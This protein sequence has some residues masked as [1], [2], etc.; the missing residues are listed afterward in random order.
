MISPRL[1]PPLLFAL[2]V[3]AQARA[4]EFERIVI[5]DNFPGAYQVE[6]ADVNGD[7]KPDVIAV[8]GG[9]CA[10]YENPSWK[11]RVVTTSKQTPGIISSA[12][13]DL[14][15]DGKAEIAIA[16]EFAM[17][18]PTKG[19][20]L[21]ASQGKT[22]DDPWIVAEVGDVP[23]IH[24]LRWASV[25]HPKKLDLVVAPIFGP[26]ARPP[27]FDQDR[28]E[29]RVYR[30]GDDPKSGRW[31]YRNAPGGFIVH[32][33]EVHADPTGSYGCLILSANHEGVFATVPSTD[34]QGSPSFAAFHVFPIPPGKAPHQ[35]SS[36][37]H[38]G[39]FAEG[40]WFLATIDPWHGTR[41]VIRPQVDDVDRK[42]NIHFGPP[43]VIDDTLNDGHAL[44]VADVDGDGVD[45]VFAGHRG[46]DHRVSVYDF[47]GKTWVRTVLDSRIAAQDLR[48]GDLDGDNAPDVVAVGGSIH[49]V[50]WYRPIGVKKPKP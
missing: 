43:V 12:S 22:L 46:K 8:G 29:L 44:W 1:V 20:L 17:N 39:R 37:V 32:A 38:L 4:V 6:V 5:D 18:E 47:N 42:T 45:E 19:K 21:V 34:P 26:K 36:E 9:T 40:R 49:N 28:A 41:V 35:G 15:G 14:D 25:S 2:A 31:T 13:A 24:R 23:S 30:T 10:W 33:I 27:A 11:K 7:G 48:G 16:Y 3:A 50:V